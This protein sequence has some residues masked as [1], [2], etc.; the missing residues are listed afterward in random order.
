MRLIILSDAELADAKALFELGEP[1]HRIAKHLGITHNALKARL[2]R[3]DEMREKGLSPRANTKAQPQRELFDKQCLEL[4]AAANSLT[5]V[6]M[7]GS[8]LKQKIKDGSAKDRLAASKFALQHQSA[9]FAK[10]QALQ[11]D[12]RA[13]LELLDEADNKAQDE[14]QNAAEARKEADGERAK[15]RMLEALL[16]EHGIPLPYSTDD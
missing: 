4:S 12:Y 6:R 14:A 16:A 7:A 5:L 8:A 1:P 15:R 3:G 2:Q 9:G 10:D 13:L 11:D